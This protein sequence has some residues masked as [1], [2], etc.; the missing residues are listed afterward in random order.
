M[1]NNYE[2]TGFFVENSTINSID[3]SWT[4]PFNTDYTN[5]QIDY[6]QVDIDVNNT[7]LLG[8]NS[9]YIHLSGLQPGTTIIFTFT[10][11]KNS[12][13]VANFSFTA[14]NRI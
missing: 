8:V 10:T 13:S 5:I 7:E 11:L 4:P 6:Y 3:L 9:S 1:T 2:V 12:I 14:I